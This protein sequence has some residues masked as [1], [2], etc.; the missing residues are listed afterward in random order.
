MNKE[1][2]DELDKKILACI[3]V[4]ALQPA[5]QIGEKIGLSAS[6]IQRRI[7]KMRQS[8]LIRSVVAL[9]DHK[10]VGANVTCIVSVDLRRELE[11]DIDGFAIA[12]RKRPEVQQ[13]YYVTGQADFVMVVITPTMDAYEAFTREAFLRDPNIESFTTH[14]VLDAIKV[15]SG[16]PLG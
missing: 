5:T 14:V 9:V 3:Q 13:I 12:M 11:A 1:L 6:S 2:C 15:S 4:D 8:G 7:K 16:V 10:K